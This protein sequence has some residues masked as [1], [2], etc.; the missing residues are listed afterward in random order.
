MLMKDMNEL[1][2]SLMNKA[3]MSTL[4]E[5]RKEVKHLHMRKLVINGQERHIKAD[6]SKK[7]ADQARKAA[8]EAAKML[9]KGGDAG[10][11]VGYSAWCN[12]VVTDNYDVGIIINMFTPFI[13]TMVWARDYVLSKGIKSTEWRKAV[14]VFKYVFGLKEDKGEAYVSPIQCTVDALNFSV[15]KVTED[16]AN[17]VFDR[18]VNMKITPEN[19]RN[20]SRDLVLVSRYYGEKTIDA[21]KNGTDIN[22][23][24][25]DRLIALKEDC[26][27]QIS[28]S[29]NWD[30]KKIVEKGLEASS[31]VVA[32]QIVERVSKTQEV[33]VEDAL[34]ELYKVSF[35]DAFNDIRSRSAASLKLLAAE[36]LEAPEQTFPAE[37][38]K[39]VQAFAK[40]EKNA[41]VMEIARMAKQIYSKAATSLHSEEKLIASMFKREEDVESEKKILSTRKASIYGAITNLLRLG[42]A[43]VSPENRAKAVIAVCTEGKKKGDKISGFIDSALSAEMFVFAM[44]VICKDDEHKAEVAKE[45]L[46][47]NS[48]PNGAVITIG[49][50]GWAHDEEGHEAFA[51]TLA[52]YDLTVSVEI[53]ENGKAWAVH[54][55][56]SLVSVPKADKTK[57]CFM[58]DGKG[59]KDTATLLRFI[60]ES[61]GKRVVLVPSDRTAGVY[62]AVVREDT[63]DVVGHFKCSAHKYGKSNAD[64]IASK[65]V[66]DL[67]GFK[68]GMIEDFYELTSSDIDEDGC[69][70]YYHRAFVVLGDVQEHANTKEFMARFHNAQAKAVKV[71][72]VQENNN[73]YLV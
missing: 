32:E 53:D 22:V 34:G 19:V 21:V 24:F 1:K 25:A 55:L 62:N 2:I 27:K 61:W 15:L 16:E 64:R 51:P 13:S 35:S 42:M 66:N 11:M 26:K 54:D 72:K 9:G 14:D 28:V 59:N 31:T 58:T 5:C 43:S 45:E 56:A 37:A 71:R 65:A 68:S 47:V 39:E 60:R 52:G 49:S 6:V 70:G 10:L 18:V 67:Y 17:K 38:W 29:I 69:T 36:V 73:P 48:F 7:D 33:P 4:M 63:G 41:G 3:D 20:A 57:I 44:N 50:D 23:P 8:Q 46:A 30:E 12:V 40:D